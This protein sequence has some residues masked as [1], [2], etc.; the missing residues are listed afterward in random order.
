MYDTGLINSLVSQDNYYKSQDEVRE[1]RHKAIKMSH[2]HHFENNAFYNKFCKARGIGKDI[3]EKT[4][5]DL[6]IPD[7]VFKSYEMENP[8]KEP[9]RFKKWVD[10]ISSVRPE[11]TLNGA[12]SLEEL[13]VQFQKSG[14]F[15]GYSSGTSG[16]LT[17][18]PRDEFTRSM[19]VRS[20]VEAVDATIKVNKGKDFFVLGI[21]ART[22]LQVGFNG[23]TTAEYLSPGNIYY[24]MKELVSDI[25]RL[26]MRGP[27]TLKEMVINEAMKRMLP[28]IE[29]KA[30]KGI[31]DTLVRKKGGRIIFMAPPFLI[32]NSARY[33]LDNGLDVKL[34]ADSVLASTGGFKGRKITSRDEMNKLIKEAFNVDE[35]RYIDLYGMTESNSIMVECTEGNN[36]HIPPWKEVVLFDDHM[37]PIEPK[38]KVTGY[39]GFLEASSRSFPGFIMT[40]D[41]IT[42]DYDGCPSCKKKTPVV[43][44]IGRA[45]RTEGRGCAGV[46]SK[47]VGGA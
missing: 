43:S 33:I 17:F 47:T 14:L 40:G 41:K 30:V 26:R 38:G 42:V 46:L 25:V 13:L 44:E 12:K 34:S 10:S 20:Y 19:I 4:F 8:E 11:V 37:E 22:F 5:P 45:P 2:M 9:V 27:K 18:L 35:N 6:L 29:K 31:V 23:R 15:L 1:I 28:G 3:T 16:K 24:A 39:Y 21:P 32:V 7:S 36:K